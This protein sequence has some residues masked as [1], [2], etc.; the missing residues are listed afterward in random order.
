MGI[1]EQTR[2][3]FQLYLYFHAQGHKPDFYPT[4]F[5]VLRKDPMQ[6]RTGPSTSVVDGDGNTVTSNITYGKAD[7]RHMAKK[8][9]DAA[10]LDLSELFEVNGMFKPYDKQFIGDYSNYWAGSML[11]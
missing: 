2:M 10:Q 5:K 6:K 1:W 4:L 7:Y 8:M 9:C 11:I 3:Y